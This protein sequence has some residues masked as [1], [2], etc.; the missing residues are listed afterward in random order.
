M[1]PYFISRP[2]PL[3]IQL[4][5]LFFI[6]DQTVLEWKIDPTKDYSNGVFGFTLF[7]ANDN[8]V[9]QRKPIYTDTDGFISVNSIETIKFATNNPDGFLG[10]IT[11]TMQG[12][13]QVFHCIDC[14]PSTTTELGRL[15]L[16]TDMSIPKDLPG[17][18]YCKDTCT[19]IKIQPGKLTL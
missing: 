13:K 8:I 14:L 16:D 10:L 7:D 6:L 15:F 17:T 9:G 3:F 18:A 5:I 19:F 12:E 4:L 2:T 11:V 1:V